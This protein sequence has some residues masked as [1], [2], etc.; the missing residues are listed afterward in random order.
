MR[1]N[2]DFS[3]RIQF[4]HRIENIDKIRSQFTVTNIAQFIDVP[5]KRTCVFQC[6]RINKCHNR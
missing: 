1:I 3:V 6:Y 4:V 5:I 2:Q